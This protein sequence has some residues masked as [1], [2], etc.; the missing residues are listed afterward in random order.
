MNVIPIKPD[1]IDR[2]VGAISV[3]QAIEAFT[4]HPE[5]SPSARLLGIE[6]V[7]RFNPRTLKCFPSEEYLSAA[8]TINIRTVQRAKAELREAGLIDWTSGHRGHCCDYAI[9]WLRLKEWLQ[10]F[11]EGWEAECGVGDDELIALHNEIQSDKG[12]H[13]CHP[14]DDKG[15]H[16][17]QA[18]NGKDD[19]SV[20]KGRHLTT[21]RATPVSYLL[22]HKNTHESTQAH[23]DAVGDDTDVSPPASEEKQGTPFGGASES[24]LPQP[25]EPIGR[26]GTENEP[27]GEQPQSDSINAYRVA[28]LELDRLLGSSVRADTS[29][30]LFD[31][32]VEVALAEGTSAA[33]S[34]MSMER[35]K[36]RARC[37]A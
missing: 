24:Q 16:E 2:Y 36:N 34:F 21:E 3:A 6:L 23:A 27:S 18:L 35:T 12:R 29:R 9:S 15:R 4:K 30:E 5:L 28:K 37:S 7:S 1:G 31:K 13:Q 11:R 14:I 19:T 33:L 8:L 22:S 26:N 10:E 25:S 32:G 17:C 20:D